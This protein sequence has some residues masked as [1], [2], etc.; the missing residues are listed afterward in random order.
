MLPTAGF[1]ALLGAAAPVWLLC[2]GGLIAGAGLTSGDIF[3]VTTFQRFVP[4]HLLSRLSSFD[5]LGSVALNPIGYALVGPL[6]S[7]IGIAQTIYIAATVN[8]AISV[9]VAILPAIRGLHAN[10]E[11]TTVIAVEA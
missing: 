8:A 6:A 3:W 5:W 10:E 1:L 11:P 7:R 9:I 4:E 2:I